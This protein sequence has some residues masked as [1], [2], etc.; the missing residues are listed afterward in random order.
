MTEA[1]GVRL[2]LDMPASEEAVE[3]AHR[4]ID[5]LWSADDS[6]SPG[7]RMRFEL[8]VIEI[9]GN[10]VEHAWAVDPEHR[11]SRRLWMNL[12]VTTDRVT[13]LL[14][15]NGEPASLDLSAATMPGEDAESGRGLP[16][17]MAALDSLDYSREG[18]R[19]TWSLVCERRDG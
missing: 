2:T 13:A 1:D 10:I 6:V 11:A 7:D 17:A 9:L 15:D 16:L 14:G 19:N 4:Q 3:L 12:E 18:G 5:Q 8:A